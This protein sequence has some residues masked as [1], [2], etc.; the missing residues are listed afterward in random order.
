[1]VHSSNKTFIK[2]PKSEHIPGL[3]VYNL[4]LLDKC[5]TLPNED[6]HAPGFEND[7]QV[8]Y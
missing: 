4:L 2:S 6:L 3:T 5:F 1:M 7:N 8:V